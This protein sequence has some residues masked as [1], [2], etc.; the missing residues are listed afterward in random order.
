MR[1]LTYKIIL[2]ANILLAVSILVSYIS[3]H[4]DPGVFAIP[5][6]F[7]LAYPYL[8]LANIIFALVW[9]AYLKPEALI[10]I[11]VIAAGFTHFSNYL[12][13]TRPSGDK[14]G[15]LKVMSYNVHLFNNFEGRNPVRTEKK[16]AELIRNQKPDVICLQEYYL[17]GDADM[18][19]KSFIKLIG[20]EY[21]AHMK[22]LGAS[23]NRYY[24]ILTLS[25]HPILRKGDIVHPGS[26]SLSIFTDILAGKDTLRIYNNHLQS[27]RLRKMD[28][29]LINE[30]TG[31]T[32]NRETMNEIRDISVSLRKGFAIRASQA[33]VLKEHVNQSP[34]SVIIAGDFND[35][36]VSYTYR[37][38]RK[39]LND[40]FV[41]SGYGAGFTYKGNYPANRIDYI[42]YDKTLV[43]R[44][45]DILRVRYSDHYPIISY[46]RKAD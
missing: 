3:V 7:G 16:I 42:L 11:I 26:G 41:A 40:A 25:R 43:C 34:W 15:T 32:D 33:R 46:L 20:S 4:I 36:P 22:S 23:K 39:G 1:K 21:H 8:L 31:K 28:T 13:V 9:L 27:F 19:G 6:L 14:T 29:H 2:A 24:G 35:T 10:S 5:S 17:G 12:K 38:L 18:S 37:K 45:F 30:L 44:Q